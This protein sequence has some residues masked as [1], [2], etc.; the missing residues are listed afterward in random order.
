MLEIHDQPSVTGFTV[1]LENAVHSELLTDMDAVVAHD[2]NHR[3]PGIIF[4]TL[5]SS[6]TK[7]LAT[8]EAQKR[9]G[10]MRR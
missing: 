6:A 4:A 8:Y 10:V 1:N 2:F 9:A 7:A 5:V 3:L